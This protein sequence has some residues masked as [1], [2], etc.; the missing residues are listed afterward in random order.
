MGKT[1]LKILIGLHRNVNA[2]DKKTSKIAAEYNLTFSQFMVLEVLYS[3]GDMSVGEVR[4]RILSSVGTIP[5]IVNN[6]VK[7]NYVERLT[8]E[9]DRRV[10]I[11]H[12]TKDG[13]DVISKVAP[14]NEEMI[15]ESM[16][17]LEQEERENL[18]YLLKKLG[19]KSDEKK[20]E[21]KSKGL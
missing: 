21:D 7:R 1:E 16:G 13:Y 14:E 5:L 17:V 10:C 18:L 4:E 19:G 9:K 6:L 20:S 2:I 15:A 12:L 11:L 8:D 3:K